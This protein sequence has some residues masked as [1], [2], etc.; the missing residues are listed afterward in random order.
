[1]QFEVPDSK[2]AKFLEVLKSV[3]SQAIMPVRLLA[4][5][6][7]LLNLFS[8]AL[9][10]VVRLMT[11]SLYSCLHLAYF[12]QESWGSFTSLT[13]S[14]WEELRFWESNISKLKGFTIAPITPSITTCEAI[15]G[16]ASGK[17]LYAA[18]FSDK[19]STV[20]SRKLKTAEKSE[21][22][23]YH[24]CLVILGIYTESLSPIFSFRGKQ[25]LHLTDNKGVASI[26]T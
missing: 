2:L 15:A 7:G 26:F 18:H 14:A 5:L 24:E 20:F 16:N 13:D 12:S 6:L 17:G 19:N 11:R 21:S 23:T 9:G 3:K 10:Q 4:C 1:M 8:R 25:I 22:S